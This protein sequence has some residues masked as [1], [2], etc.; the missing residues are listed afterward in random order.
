MRK[1]WFRRKGVSTMIGGI[2]VLT[3]FLTA[4]VAM[5]GVS[6]QYDRY[7]GTV[8]QMIQKDTE[9]FSEN[10]QVLFPG[11]SFPP[12]AVSCLGSGTCD[13]FT[14]KI[15]NLAGIGTQIARIYI[16][17]TTECAEICILDPA[18]VPANSTFSF[19]D[20]FI[21]PSEP[22]HAIDFWLAT[23]KL[24]NTTGHTFN[25]VTTRGRVFSLTWP[26]PTFSGSAIP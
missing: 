6:Q 13:Q 14:M 3:I 10:L 17:S 20:G 12:T 24:T 15:V 11:I 23:G 1:L 16:N 4:L 18:S 7:Q 26:M 8:K 25:I 22:D 19:Y 21:N 5:V 9:R 2:L